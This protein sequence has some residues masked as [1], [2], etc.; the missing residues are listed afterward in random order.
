MQ[1]IFAAYV[2]DLNAIIVRAMPYRT[3]ASMVTAFTEVITILKAGGYQLALNVMDNEC[4]AAIKKYIK[5][6]NINI[7]L[8]PPHNHCV[9]AAERA[10]AKFKEH[11]IAALAT[12]DTHCPLQLWDEF[13]LQ[14]ELTL[15]M[16][17]FSQ[18]NP[19]KS[20]N[21]EVYGSID[22]TKTP[23]ALLGTKALI[24]DDPVSCASWVPHS[25][26][27]STS[28]QP[29]ITTHA[30]NSTS[31]PRN[32]SGSPTRGAYIQPTARSRSLHNTISPLLLQQTSSRHL[33]TLYLQQRRKKS[34]ISER[35]KT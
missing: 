11:F 4:S 32:A 17:R 19:N 27:V 14:V 1:Y 9:N 18:Q 34:G 23:L 21:Q 26:M 7:Q 30:S 33:G 10:I 31:H 15:N 3:D 28:A 13:L 2:Y 5:S 24:Y 29:P 8:V 35:F 16:L 25:T 22:F 12:M 6:E 20:A